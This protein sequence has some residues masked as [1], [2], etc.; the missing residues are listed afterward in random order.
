MS[1][2]N[3][4]DRNVFINC[5]FDSD[6]KPLFEAIVFTVQLV[7]LR[8]RC[9]EEAI[10]AGEV[11]LARIMSIISDCK[12]GIHD[13]SRMQANPLPRFN[14]PFELGLDLGAKRYGSLRHKVKKL[15]I[16]DKTPYRYRR[17]I[18]DIAGLDIV[19]HYNGPRHIVRSVRDWLSDDLPDP[20]QSGQ[21]AYEVYQTFREELASRCRG[22]RQDVRSLR[23]PEYSRYVRV[24]LEEEI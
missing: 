5:P 11:R 23:F 18:S 9:G 1:K 14:M 16:L 22:E 4:Y 13:I 6:Y 7:G 12:Y 17:V 8:P 19:P 20:A 21:H 10:N 15:L 3:Q 24:W 2:A